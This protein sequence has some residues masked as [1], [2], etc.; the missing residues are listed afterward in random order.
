VLARIFYE[1]GI[2]KK[3]MLVETD[4]EGLIGAYV[5]STAIK[6]KRKIEEALGGVLF[7]D[8][9]Y[10]LFAGDNIDYGHEALAVLVKMME[11]KRDEFVCI[12]AGYTNEMNEM[13]NMNPG[14]RDRIGF[15]IDFPDYDENELMQIYKKLCGDN[16]YKLSQA[17]EDTLARRF[18]R[19]VR[20][21]SKNFSNGRLVRKLFE[22]TRMKQALRTSG[23]I[24]TDADVNAVFAENDINSLFENGS[25]LQIGFKAS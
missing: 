4:R 18:S 10:S 13:L 8:E 19:L 1:T 16:K 11:D 23:N 25:R 12:V 3:N 22:R 20:H 15:Y 24:I 17:A 14:L 6:T 21:K 2:I 7:I 5:G 9:A